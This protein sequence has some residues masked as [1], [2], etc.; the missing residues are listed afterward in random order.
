[1]KE[2]LPIDDGKTAVVLSD[3]LLQCAGRL[4]IE[5]KA[6]FTPTH[7]EV[8]EKG[9]ALADS[10]AQAHYGQG[11]SSAGAFVRWPSA[12]RLKAAAPGPPQAC[13]P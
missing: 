6:R 9:L 2:E 3:K 13:G 12:T 7:K 5:A 11:A 4:G 1:V 8:V 10:T